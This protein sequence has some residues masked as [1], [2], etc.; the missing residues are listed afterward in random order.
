MQMNFQ[1][2]LMPFFLKIDSGLINDVSP[3]IR[4][5]LNANSKTILVTDRIVYNLYG[6]LVE[7]QLKLDFDFREV[8]FV[9]SNDISQSFGL[10]EF[11]LEHD[12]EMIIGLGGGKVLDV[13]KHTSFL[14]K[15]KFVS[16]PTAIANDGV[17]SP[18]TVLNTRNGV[19]SLGCKVPN[20]IIIDLDVIQSS[21]MALKRAG[22]GDTLSN[23]T[24]ILDWKYAADHG[25]DVV[26]DFAL[27]L[28]ITSFN[29]LI[30]YKN[31][32]IN[33]LNFL[34]QLSE[35]I[36]LSGLAMNIAGTSRPC[37]GSEHL[38]SHSMDRYN[39]GNLHGI[40]VAVCSVISA[41]LHGKNI[42]SL[43]S[44]LHEFN[45]PF[46]LKLLGFGLEEFI[47]IMQNASGTRPNR[48][49]ILND[50]DMSVESLTSLHNKLFK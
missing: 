39:K 3:L 13:A 38:I 37:S 28:S 42:E 2:I 4:S 26:N 10:S 16:I 14:T 18:I 44:F 11:I 25:R 31:R 19:K 45:I 41:F 8:Y 34:R 21:P 36:I 12:I 30:N 48:Y 22:I 35:S 40:Q 49:T 33:D 29:A 17:S 23:Y 1:E 32:D 43:K 50:T 7:D 20:G 15:A 47:E 27:L 9:E 24:A 6:K 46:S 5:I